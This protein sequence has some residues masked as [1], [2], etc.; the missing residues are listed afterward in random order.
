MND[1]SPFLVLEWPCDRAVDWLITSLAK[2]GFEVRRTFDLQSARQAHPP[3][4]CPYHG[5]SPCDCQWIV[6]LVY[7]SQREQTAITVYGYDQT[8][9]ISIV[10]TPHQRADPL[11]EDA[12]RSML[13]ASSPVVIPVQ[14]EVP[15]K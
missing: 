11:L 15:S 14:N 6:L 1:N 5:R 7:H 3:T 4:P 12:L 2:A 8:T 9:C 13:P 10:D